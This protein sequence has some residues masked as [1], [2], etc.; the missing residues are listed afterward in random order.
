LRETFLRNP[1]ER[2]RQVFL[3]QGNLEGEIL[4]ETPMDTHQVCLPP[5][6]IAS[7]QV[8]AGVSKEAIAT[9]EER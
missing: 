2:K 5:I 7:Q 8:E 9:K 3:K 1:K 4:A 6:E